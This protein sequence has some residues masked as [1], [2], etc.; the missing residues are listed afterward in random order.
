MKTSWSRG[1]LSA[2]RCACRWCPARRHRGG[3]G[4][5]R[6][7]GRAVRVGGGLRERVDGACGGV[8]GVR[9][10]VHGGVDVRT[11]RGVCGGPG[12]RQHGGGLGAIVRLGVRGATGGVVGMQGSRRWVGLHRAGVGLQCP[13][14]EEGL[15]LGRAERRRIQLGC[16]RGATTRAGRDG[17]FGPRTRAAIRSWQ[18]SRGARATGYLDGAAA[19]ALR[20]AGGSG[21]AVAAA[22]APGAQPPPLVATAAQET[23]F[24][25]SIANSTNP[26]SSRRT[27]GSSRTGCS[28]RWRGRGWRRYERR[29]GPQR[30]LLG[31]RRPGGSP[32]RAGRR[33]AGAAP[34]SGW[35]RTPAAGEVFRDCAECPEMVVLSAAGW[36]WGATR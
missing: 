3:A 7:S 26:R 30:R 15:G 11:V 8:G 29:R 16:G 23:V 13:V 18:T 25:Q 4:D 34:Y 12:R 32:R 5:R 27:W 9:R 2:S 35:G 28:A 17:L 24:W 14:V 19:E 10:G 1:R 31:R 20:T 36:R 22:A 33:R 21:P 6:A